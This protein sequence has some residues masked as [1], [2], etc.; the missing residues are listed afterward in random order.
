MEINS[1]IQKSVKNVP[2]SIIQEREM[3]LRGSD[4]VKSLGICEQFRQGYFL[5]RRD[6][7][8]LWH[9]YTI[10]VLINR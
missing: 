4:F 1:S 9:W 7:Q 10:R 6:A 2:P 8:N 3:N 5:K